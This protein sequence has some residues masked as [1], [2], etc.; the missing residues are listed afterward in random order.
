MR[1]LRN[2]TRARDQKDRLFDKN[3]YDNFAHNLIDLTDCEISKLTG[4][5]SIDI[6]LRYIYEIYYGEIKEILKGKQLNVL[7]LGAGYGRH[8][9]VL[10]EPGARVV[11]LDISKKSLDLNMKLNP[12]IS[13]AL[14]ASIDMIPLADRSVDF[15]VSCESL[16]YADP[17]KTNR[18]IYRVLKPGGYLVVL[19]SLNHN[20]VYIINRLLKVIRGTRTFN[21]IYRIPNV[22]RIN[23]LSSRFENTKVTYFGKWIWVSSVLRF[24]L[25]V[26]CVFRINLILDRLGPKRLAFKFILVC[27]KFKE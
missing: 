10:L 22:K 20:P 8:T 2:F 27:K 3:N 1:I 26:S 16:S 12:K 19:D 15:V 21:S 6:L 7:E 18:E 17:S 23:E 13:G 25:P 9:N 14:L 11:V 4:I 5:Q 24:I